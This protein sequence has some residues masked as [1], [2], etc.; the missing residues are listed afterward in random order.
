MGKTEHDKKLDR[1]VSRDRSRG[2]SVDLKAQTAHSYYMA[3]LRYYCSITG[4]DP[5][6]GKIYKQHILQSL[7]SIKHLSKHRIP[8]LEN[9]IK[10]RMQLAK[11]EDN[12][13]LSRVRIIQRP[14]Q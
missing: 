5:P 14:R 11:L 2:S 9:L 12:E 8:S 1:S 4:P 10:S 6:Q 7:A 3:S 13:V